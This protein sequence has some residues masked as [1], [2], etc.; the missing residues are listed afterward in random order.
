L[1]G[2]TASEPLNVL[3]LLLDS[4]TI[5]KGLPGSFKVHHVRPTKKGG[6]IVIVVSRSGAEA[7]QKVDWTIRLSS[8]GLVKFIGG[9]TRQGDQDEGGRGQGQVTGAHGGSLTPQSSAW[10]R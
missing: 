8:A 4:Q 1:E 9:H 6:V 10:R 5:L 7:L 2:S 3:Q